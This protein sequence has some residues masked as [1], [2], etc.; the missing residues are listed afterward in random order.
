MQMLSHHV[1]SRH[2]G[3]LKPDAF[4]NTNLCLIIVHQ[5]PT[6]FPQFLERE[7]NRS[8]RIKRMFVVDLFRAIL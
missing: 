8:G 4:M 3:S 5:V 2:H 6:L 7:Q 1:R